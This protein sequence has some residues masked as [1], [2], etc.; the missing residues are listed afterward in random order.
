MFG[1]DSVQ[2]PL[3]VMIVEFIRKRCVE[4]KDMSARSRLC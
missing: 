3:K 4:N 1:G 2:N